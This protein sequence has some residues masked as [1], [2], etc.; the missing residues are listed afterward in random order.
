[1]K[2]SEEITQAFFS[3]WEESPRNSKIIPN[4]SLVPNND[5]TLLFVNSGMF[6]IVPYLGGQEHPLGK[7]LCNMQRVIRTIDIDEVGDN[8]HLTFFEMIGNWS[9]GDFT[10]KEQISWCLELY[11]EKFGLDPKRLYIT[12]W[13]GDETV[14]RDDEAIFLW[15]EAF[16]KYNINAL[17]SDDITKIPEHLLEEKVADSYHIFAYGKSDNWWMRGA[18][19][20]GELGG[21]SSEIFYDLGVKERHQEIYHINDDSGRFIE[22]GNNVF[23]EYALDESLNWKPLPQK[24]IDF[25]GGFDRIM[26]AVQNKNDAFATDLFKPIISFI[27]AIS[28]KTYNP[29]VSPFEETRAFRIVADHARAATFILADNVIPSNKD[30]GYILRRLIRRM[31]RYALQLGIEQD[32]TAQVAIMVIEKMNPRY[33]Y[34]ALMQDEILKELAK[35]EA[36]FR[37]TLRKGLEELNKVSGD[38]EKFTGKKAFYLYETYGFPIEMIL[39]ELHIEKDAALQLQQEFNDEQEHH[40]QASRKGAE[41]KFTGGLSDH[42]L[43]TTRLHTAHHLLLKALQEVLGVDVK[44]KGS[45]ITGERLRLDFNYFEKLSE[46]QIQKIESIVNTKIKEGLFVT[47]ITLPIAEAE[48]IG[49]EQ[50]F[51]QKYP[52]KVIVYFIS[53]NSD[54]TSENYREKDYFSAEF[55]GGPH[56]TN[57]LELGDE[58]QVFKIIKQESIGSGLRRIKAV[59]H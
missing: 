51:G 39:D 36:R 41:Q 9:L 46:L 35:E 6:P 50:E 19:V 25:G 17:F 59:L 37:I 14:P 58:N 8:R 56:V 27:E 26:F 20:C 43:L 22:I 47:H 48:A 44:Q 45:N 13:A 54:I 16:K 15:Q 21:P 5:P 31:I 24:N 12:V 38:F 42:S 34:L 55:C 18:R 49:A 30:Q 1:M 28:G 53:K 2:T 11:V 3:F 10:K 32:F 33:P 40:K 57:T 23:M 29:G 7:R 52:D 4:A